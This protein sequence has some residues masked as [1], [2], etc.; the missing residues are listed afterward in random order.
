MHSHDR[1]V[2][3][4]C[5]VWLAFSER[6]VAAVV[7]GDGLS[8]E[9]RLSSRLR[10]DKPRARRAVRRAMQAAAMLLLLGPT[11]AWTSITQTQY[12]AQ[13]SN[14]QAMQQH[15]ANFSGNSQETLGFLWTLPA[16]S[17]D[18]RGLGRGIAYA[19]DPLLCDAL[20]PAFNENLI[21]VDLVDCNDLQAALHRA[22][23]SWSANHELIS[24]VDV[25][26]ECANGNGGNITRDCNLVE[27]WITAR[28]I[29]DTGSEIAASAAPTPL[30]V[31]DFRYT[32]G[33][34]PWVYDAQG[35]P[36]SIPVIET[37]GGTISFA[38][39]DH[40]VCWYLLLGQLRRVHD[41]ERGVRDAVGAPP[42]VDYANLGRVAAHLD[43]QRLA[44]LLQQHLVVVAG[45]EQR[46][47]RAE[48]GVLLERERGAPVVAR[49]LTHVIRKGNSEQP[50]CDG[51]AAVVRRSCGG[52]APDVSWGGRGLAASRRPARSL[53]APTWP[54]PRR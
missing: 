22:M 1:A 35:V 49:E 31:S 48:L 3:V 12:G 5:G 50:N 40:G 33:E 21:F 45:E 47:S 14:I 27:L 51:P 17:T 36:Q 44:H 26:G 8:V 42:H 9:L 13:L 18:P 2:R 6:R 29:G 34:S 41:T 54:G 37:V 7:R 20:L 39:E 43:D 25:S 32:N 46:G 38:T 16:S 30:V 4:A 11:D 23:S 15:S 28:P 24:F 52:R 19:W 10:A 53:R